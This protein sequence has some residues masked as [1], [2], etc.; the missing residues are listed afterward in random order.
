M[1][2]AVAALRPDIDVKVAI[3]QGKRIVILESV[4]KA[5]YEKTPTPQG[6]SLF[7]HLTIP[8]QH[9]M[10]HKQELLIYVPTVCSK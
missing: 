6:F 4:D 8:E 1:D 2:E 5:L 3:A 9:F 10:P 7:K